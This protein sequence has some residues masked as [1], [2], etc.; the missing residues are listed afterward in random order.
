MECYSKN[1]D[2]KSDKLNDEN[3]IKL[4]NILIKFNDLIY[5]IGDFDIDNLSNVPNNNTKL[6]LPKLNMLNEIILKI[7]KNTN[8]LNNK[9]NK[10][11]KFSSNK[12]AEI[13]TLNNIEDK[14]KFMYTLDN[15]L[16]YDINN[17]DTLINISEDEIDRFNNKKKRTVINIS[18][19]VLH[20]IN[21]IPLYNNNLTLPIISNL[22]YL[23][24]L[25][26]WFNGDIINKE[27]IYLRLI[28]NVIAEIPFPNLYSSKHEQF[29]KKTIRCKYYNYNTCLNIRKKYAKIHKTNIKECF[30]THQNEKFNKV[31]NIYR[32]NL[33][34][35]GNH[36][37]LEKDLNNINIS[38]IKFLLMNSLSDLLLVIIWLQ[39]NVKKPILLNN[40]DLC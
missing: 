14:H 28:D 24:S 34:S 35:F 1:T 13:K 21:N 8:L 39:K 2:N 17:V 10:I 16:I 36:E 15:S 40:L 4:I 30:Y 7:S 33:E 12:I 9:L 11:I 19:K 29:K 25:F 5:K 18:N 20:N 3:I 27:G 37:S 6:L 23:P 38:D 31:G 26:Y 32:C 22:S